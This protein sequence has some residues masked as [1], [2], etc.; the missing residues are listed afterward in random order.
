MK[1]RIRGIKYVEIEDLFRLFLDDICRA[2]LSRKIYEFPEINPCLDTEDDVYYIDIDF[3]DPSDE[4]AFKP[5][6]DDLKTYLSRSEYFKDL[7]VRITMLNE[8]P[9]EEIFRLNQDETDDLQ[10]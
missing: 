9:K 7:D 4:W 10:F 8:Q 5:V 3:I 2:Y 6:I 1:I